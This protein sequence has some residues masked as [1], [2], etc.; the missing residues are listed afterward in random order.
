[1]AKST[2]TTITEFTRAPGSVFVDISTPKPVQQQ[3]EARRYYRDWTAAADAIASEPASET[4]TAVETP[5]ESSQPKPKTAN[6]VIIEA[7]SHST[8]A[9]SYDWISKKTGLNASTVHIACCELTDGGILECEASL[10]CKKFR[11]KPAKSEAKVS[12][13]P[14]GCED[15]SL[16]KPIPTAEELLSETLPQLIEASR[17]GIYV[18]PSKE[19]RVFDG[20][21]FIHVDPHPPFWNLYNLAKG[22]FLDLGITLKKS[23]KGVW[24]ARIPICVLTDRC[25]VESGLAG[26]EK[27]LR[28]RKDDDQSIASKISD[29]I[30]HRQFENSK[31]GYAKVQRMRETLADAA[32]VVAIVAVSWAGYIIGGTV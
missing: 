31:R 9:R 23:T 25:F 21:T 14:S 1:M 29:S 30:R 24:V 19:C 13:Q 2:P 26:V 6:D 17:W 32:G 27:T 15:T 5:T 8:L 28:T 4:P 18:I 11:L 16:P 3:Q 7:L 20:T 12:T 10:T 22:I